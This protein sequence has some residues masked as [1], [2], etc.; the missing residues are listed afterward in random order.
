MCSEILFIFKFYRIDTISAFFQQHV[1]YNDNGY[2]EIAA[3]TNKFKSLF[4]SQI[5]QQVHGCIDV[6]VQ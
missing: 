3:I 1:N 5:L 6:T 4:W 2:N